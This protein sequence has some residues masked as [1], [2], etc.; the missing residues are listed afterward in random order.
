MVVT[1]PIRTT[2]AP[3]RTPS[4]PWIIEEWIIVSTPAITVVRSV[5]R[6]VIAAA[7]IGIAITKSER[8][9]I[10][11]TYSKVEITSATTIASSVVTVVI[12]KIGRRT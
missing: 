2:P 8:P 4:I 11:I 5:E 7:I 1:H 3:A 10:R 9:A 6:T 12:S